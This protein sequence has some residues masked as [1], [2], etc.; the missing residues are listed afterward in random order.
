MEEFLKVAE[1]APKLK[2]SE[3]AL[4]SA[5]RE[6]K[7]P[8]LRIGRRIRIP[9]SLLNRW[10]ESSGTANLKPDEDSFDSQSPLER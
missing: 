9:I 10:I 8:A 7:F 2:M 5:I 6:G 3:Q 1:A 4:Y